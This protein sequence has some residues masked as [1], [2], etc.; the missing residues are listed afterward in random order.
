M[1]IH[2][3]ARLMLIRRV[4]MVE[5]VYHLPSCQAAVRYAVSEATVRKWLGRFLAEE[6][7]WVA[8]RVPRIALWHLTRARC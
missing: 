1:N 7:R 4:E 2:A 8:R 6:G 5:E 3:N